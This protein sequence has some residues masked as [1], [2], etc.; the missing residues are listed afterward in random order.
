MLAYGDFLL[1][2][3]VAGFSYDNCAVGN[4]GLCARGGAHI[5]IALGP[6]SD[7]MRHIDRIARAAEQMVG[8]GERDEALGM[9]RRGENVA[10]IVDADQIV[11]RRMKDQQRL[12][13]FGDVG[14][15]ILLRDIVNERFAD[16]ERTPG[17]RH[18]DFALV[19]DLSNAIRKQTDHMGRIERRRDR[20]HRPRFGNAMRGGK[21][22]GAAAAVAD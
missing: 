22:G 2:Q 13:Q 21:H 8:A 20:H 17:E 9:F 6:S 19:F 12:V 1:E 4:F 3:T 10:R 16:M 15:E 5:E 18:L 14:R 11:G 7:D